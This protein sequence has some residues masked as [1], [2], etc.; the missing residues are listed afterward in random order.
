[1][2]EVHDSLFL[3]CI[4]QSRQICSA[5]IVGTH[6]G[7]LGAAFLKEKEEGLSRLLNSFFFLLSDLCY[8]ELQQNVCKGVNAPDLS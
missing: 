5:E 8:D 6:S 2:A 1:M 4:I 3:E 7:A